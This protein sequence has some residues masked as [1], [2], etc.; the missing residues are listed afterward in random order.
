VLLSLLG[1]WFAERKGVKISTVLRQELDTTVDMADIVDTVDT[2][3]TIIINSLI[4]NLIIN[5][6]IN[7]LISSP[8]MGTVNPDVA[9]IDD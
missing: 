6:I 8:T 4:N 3:I 5:L 9:A 1:A 7:N 2:A